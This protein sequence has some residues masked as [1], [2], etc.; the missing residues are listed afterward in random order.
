MPTKGSPAER[1]TMTM[2]AEL[3]DRM[4]RAES[5]CCRLVAGA[6]R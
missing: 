6:V 1:V 2:P 4:D 5:N 3:V